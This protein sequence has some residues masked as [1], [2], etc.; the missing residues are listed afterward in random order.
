[1]CWQRF[2]EVGVE[3]ASRQPFDRP[4]IS[5]TQARRLKRLEQENAS[6]RRRL[7]LS[8]QSIFRK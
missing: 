3:I 1:V 2:S 4:A 5:I 8:E 7:A 6:L